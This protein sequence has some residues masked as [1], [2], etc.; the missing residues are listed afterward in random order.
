MADRPT[1]L[2]LTLIAL[3]LWGLLLRPLLAPTPGIAAGASPRPSRAPA[4][5]VSGATVYLAQ[6]G[7]LVTYQAD[8]LQPHQRRAYEPDLVAKLG[9]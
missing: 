9:P 8:T 5:A 1:R 2:L 4:L 6:D 7:V 3:A